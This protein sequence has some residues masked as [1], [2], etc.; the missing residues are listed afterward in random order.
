MPGQSSLFLEVIRWIQLVETLLFPPI[1]LVL[2]LLAWLD[3]HRYVKL[4]ARQLKEEEIEEEL[5]REVKE[6]SE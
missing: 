6:F 1:L 2:L 4:R 5:E 3:W